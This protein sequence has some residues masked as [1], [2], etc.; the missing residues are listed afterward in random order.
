MG[1]QELHKAYREGQEKYIY[2]MLAAAGAAIAFAVTQTQTATLSLSKI[3]LA[4]SVVSWGL[5]FFCGLRQI[6]QSSNLLYQNYQLLRMQAGELPEFPSDSQSVQTILSIIEKQAKRSGK[7][8]NWQFRLLIAGAV[9]YIA[10]HVLEM[11][12]RTP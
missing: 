12:L 11:Y 6:L 2:F 9:F 10:W 7:W 8:G 4:F 3:P 5:S 1:Q